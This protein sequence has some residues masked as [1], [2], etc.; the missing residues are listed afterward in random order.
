[1]NDQRKGSMVRGFALGLTGLGLA[2]LLAGCGGTGGVRG[3]GTPQALTSAIFEVEFAATGPGDEAVTIKPEH[4]DA[5][6]ESAA[7]GSSKL[8][9]TSNSNFGIKFV[10]I[11][12]QSKEQKNK[13][14]HRQVDGWNEAKCDGTGKCT[15]SL[16]LDPGTNKPHKKKEIRGAKYIVASPSGCYDLKPRP[17][18][19]KWQDPVIIVR[20]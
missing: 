15:L 9:W 16:P 10:E 8:E 4:G 14:S 19:C 13:F 2:G 11:D 6:L 12:D 5:W 17:A 20:Y 18:N 7:D 1:M 3:G